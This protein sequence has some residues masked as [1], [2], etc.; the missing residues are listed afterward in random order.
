[1]KA[2]DVALHVSYPCNAYLNTRGKEIAYADAPDALTQFGFVKTVP[3]AEYILV[4]AHANRAPANLWPFVL[5]RRRDARE[6]VADESE[7]EVLPDAIR[8]ALAKAKNPLAAG[9]VEGVLPDGATDAL[10][11]EEVVGRREEGRGRVEVCP[12]GPERLDRG[13]GG[14]FLDALLVVGNFISRRALLAEPEDPS[15]CAGGSSRVACAG[16]E[17]TYVRA[18]EGMDRHCRKPCR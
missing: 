17:G 1:M 4:L 10:V 9:E 6:L 14:N 13:K 2:E 12:E 16:L 15:M 8:D 5:V 18:A 7:D 3:N 11:E